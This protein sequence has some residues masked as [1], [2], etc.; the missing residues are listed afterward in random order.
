M[1]LPSDMAAAHMTHAVQY[2]TVQAGGSSFFLYST[3]RT[4]L[5]KV[6]APFHS[7]AL[8]LLPG[9]AVVRS[10]ATRYHTRV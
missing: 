3:V 7:A 10:S 4:G 6:A 9:F 1:L 5:G 2:A 8:V